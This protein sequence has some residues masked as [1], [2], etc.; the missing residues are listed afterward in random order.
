MTL[1]EFDNSY[2]YAFE[3]EVLTHTDT[4]KFSLL[5]LCLQHTFAYITVISIIITFEVSDLHISW[6]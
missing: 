1:Q 6:L 5:L 3:T 4:L 2:I